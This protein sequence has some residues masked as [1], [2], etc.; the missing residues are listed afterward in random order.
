[1]KNIF[2]IAIGAV[3][4][5]IFLFKK[6]TETPAELDEPKLDNPPLTFTDTYDE[7]GRQ[8]SIPNLTPAYNPGGG[9]V[10]PAY[11]PEPAISP[12]PEVIPTISTSSSIPGYPTMADFV[13]KPGLADILAAAGHVSSVGAVPTTGVKALDSKLSSP[14][15]VVI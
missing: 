2:Y 1:M 3:L 8:I 11:K 13:P 10:P 15:K 6:Q 7:T 9:F 5:Y 14:L 12:K 4:V